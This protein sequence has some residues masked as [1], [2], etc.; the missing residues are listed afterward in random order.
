MAELQSTNRTKISKVREAAYGV[1]NSNPAFIEMRT[2]ANSL[3]AGIQTVESAEIRSD[4]Q[5]TDLIVVGNDASGTING[6]LS[7][8]TW[9]DE[10][11]EALQ[12][13]WTNKPVKLCV[14]ADTEISDLSTTTATVNSGGA[15][16]VAGHLVQTT[17]FNVAGNN[18]RSRVSSSTAT[19]VV[20]P[21]STFTAEAAVPAGA[22]LKVV[23]FQ[24]AS[25]DIAATAS[26]LTSVSLDFTTLGIAAGEW[27]YVGDNGVA[28]ASFATAACAGWARVLSVGAH[29][30]TFDIFP[31]GW[32][33]D[34]GTGKV[35]IVY[36][37]DFLINGSVKRSVSFERQYLE[38][39]SPSYEYFVGMMLNNLQI[40]MPSNGVVTVQ[41]AYLGSNASITST[42]ASGATDTAPNTNEVM[43][44]SEDIGDISIDG[45]NVTGPNYV[46]A[47]TI[48]INNNLGKQN[49]VGHVGAVGVRNGKLNVTL[50]QFETYFG[51]KTLYDK[52]LAGTD[53][54]FQTTISSSDSGKNESY[55]FDLPRCRFGSGVA[56]TVSGTDADV[57]LPGNANALKHATFGYTI[58]IGR[59]SYLPATA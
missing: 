18:K 31:V 30:I 9:D 32:T 46:L 12:G 1:L 44:S 45:V 21:A 33:S 50:S 56:P 19:T 49:A 57:T 23:G 2:T 6:E 39:A 7:F 48:D 13:T 47:A 10:F 29:L 43:D 41:A 14:T 16:F 26:G 52:A 20:F 28:N 51:D 54:G 37:G 8:L 55:R 5:Q 17:G 38:H 35:I 22:K 36:A 53:F 3:S 24:G 11:E 34:A 15:S 58:S 27:L 25:G 42:R 40:A 59:F 4:R